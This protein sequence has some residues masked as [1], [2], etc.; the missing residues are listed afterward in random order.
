MISPECLNTVPWIISDFFDAA[1]NTAYVTI[2]LPPVQRS[3][4]RLRNACWSAVLASSVQCQPGVVVGPRPYRRRRTSCTTST[5]TWSEPSRRR[6]RVAAEAGSSRRSDRPT[7]RRR[8]KS[9]PVTSC[10]G[11]RRL[12]SCRTSTH[13]ASM[14]PPRRNCPNAAGLAYETATEWS[15]TC[16]RSADDE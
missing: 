6:R 16:E 4:P 2:S 10:T 15:R 14:S 13:L 12:S 11:T 1:G 3:R 7:C 9:P 5:S 8:R